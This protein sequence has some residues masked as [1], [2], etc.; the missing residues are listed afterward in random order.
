MKYLGPP[1]S[2]SQANTTASHNR[3]G[4]YLRNRRKPVSPT[5]TAKQSIQRGRFGSVSALWQSLDSVLQNAWTAFAANYP[6]VDSLGQSVVLTGQQYFIG[7]NSSLLACGA[8]LTTATPTNTTTPP[9]DAFQLYTDAGGTIIA[10]V[11]SVTEDDFNPVGLSR[12][13]SNG[14]NFNKTFSQFGVFTSGMLV[15]DLSGVYAAQY[16]APQAGK[17]IFGR[18][19]EVNSSGMSGPAV[20]LQSPVLPAS[21]IPAA[22][23]TAP[24]PGTVNI[25]WAG[26]GNYAADVFLDQGSGNVPL[27]ISE[28][29]SAVSPIVEP[30]VAPGAGYYVRLTDGTTY[31]PKSN[32]ITV[33]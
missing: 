20:I 25:T 21:A 3:A 31:G 32:L 30:G 28:L 18:C 12:V 17:K 19:K 6:V 1:Q 24:T 15:L 16:G 8:E 10:R 26:G 33:T 13:L 27:Y 7:L 11:G 5:R 14:V 22:V 9:V 4:Q 23:L 29:P 2:G